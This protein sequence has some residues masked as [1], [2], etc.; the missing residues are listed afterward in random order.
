MTQ[1]NVPCFFNIYIY[2]LNWD[3]SNLFAVEDPLFM[4]YCWLKFQMIGFNI[5]IR[6]KS[7]LSKGKNSTAH[8]STFLASEFFWYKFKSSFC[9]FKNE[10][11]VLVC[12]IFSST[13]SLSLK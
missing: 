5:K 11:N 13:L 9:Q 3:V 12:F 2:R 1:N 6:K 7:E 4:F 8:K 10:Y